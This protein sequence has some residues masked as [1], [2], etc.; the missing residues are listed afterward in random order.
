VKGTTTLARAIEGDGGLKR[1]KHLAA[2]LARTPTKGQRRTLRAAIRIE[3]TAYR[4]ALDTAQATAKH[5]PKRL[6]GVG[7]GSLRRTSASRQWT[8]GEKS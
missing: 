4:K 2:Q 7:A 3:A 5:D 8:L 1:I 6:P